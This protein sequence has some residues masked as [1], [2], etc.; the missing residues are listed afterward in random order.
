MQTNVIDLLAVQPWLA[1]GTPAEHLE[2]A[3]RRARARGL[4]LRRGVWEQPRLRLAGG[5]GFLVVGGV[6]ARRTVVPGGRSLELLGEGE[7]LRPWE[8]PG[9]P[10]GSGSSWEVLTRTAEVAVLDAGF[11]KRVAPLPS[12]AANL[13]ARTEERAERLALLLALRQCTRVERRLILLFWHLADRWGSVT[14][15][16]TLV[17]LPRLTHGELGEMIGA[18]RPSV[19]TALGRLAR[20]GTV[21]QIGQDWLLRGSVEEALAHDADR[22]ARLAPRDA[23]AARMRAV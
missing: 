13:L 9:A 22:E 14:P 21:R 15:Q 4:Y 8:R 19:T 20:R 7:L 11:A 17:R 3:R 18:R 2:T 10:P 23:A 16:G 1:Q 6:L 5:F 12:I